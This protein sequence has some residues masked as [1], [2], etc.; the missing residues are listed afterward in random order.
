M[1]VSGLNS[2]L[3]SLMFWVLL[4]VVAVLIWNVSSRLQQNEHQMRFSDFIAAAESGKVQSVEIT[5]QQIKGVSIDNETF[6]S[7]AP[8]QYEGLANRL[9]ER[10]VV[11]QAK[12]PTA[13]PWASL[14][15]TW[16]PVLLMIGF[17]V[18]FMRQMQSGGNKALSFGKSKAKL[19]SNSQKKVTFKD[20]AGVDEAKEELQEIIEFLKEPQKFQKLGGRIPKGV[21]LMGSPGTGKTLLARAV[22]GEA[23]VPFF[24]I[25]GSDFVEMFVGVGAS[26][27]RD[28][29]EQGKKNAPCI[30]FID[31]IDAVGGR[32]GGSHVGA[33]DEREQTLNQLLAEMDGF[34]PAVGVVVLAA[35]NRPDVLDPALLRPG[36]F[37][38]RVVVSRP[39]VRGR[40]GILQV[41]TRK[42]P[43]S[44]DVDITTLARATP[45]VA[46]TLL[47]ASPGMREDSLNGPPRPSSTTHRSAAVFSIIASAAGV[48]IVGDIVYL[49]EVAELRRSETDA[50]AGV[51]RIGAGASLEQAWRA[52]A[53]P[54]PTPSTLIKLSLLMRYTRKVSP[55]FDVLFGVY[56][57]TDYGRRGIQYVHYPTYLRPRPMVDLRW[58]HQPRAGLELYYGLADRIARFGADEVVIVTT[59]DGATS[60]GEFW[61]SLNAAC[62]LG[63]PVVYVVE[64]N[65][66]AISVPVEVQTA[67]G[68]ISNLVSGFPGLNVVG[69]DGTDLVDSYRAAGEAIAY[70]RRRRRPSLIHATCTR[71][72]SH[73]MSDDETAYRTEEERAAQTERDPLT[74]AYALLV[75]FRI[76]T[77]LELDALA[78][79]VEAEVAAA[80]DEA[81][82]SPPPPPSSAMRHLYSEEVDPTSAAFD[83]E[84]APHVGSDKLL[85]MVDLINSCLK[86]EM[87]RD[88]RVVVLGQDVADCSR[89]PA[90]SEVKG[91]GGVFKVTYGLQREFGS[92]RVY[93]APIAEAGIVGRA[94]GMALRGLKPVVE[95]QFFDY[96][97]PAMMQIRGELATQRYRSN[98]VFAAPVVI[99]VAYGGYLKGGAIYHS[100]TGESIFAHCPGI[101]VCMPS[102]A[103]DAAGLLR[104]AIRCEDPV[105]FL[106]HKH[107][108]RQVYNKGRD[109]GP[110]F[111]IPFGKAAVR[112]SGA[113]VTVVTCG[114]LV[115]RS[116]DA[117]RIA[118]E[119][120]GI[121]AE[122][123]DLRTVKPLD[124]ECIAD[125]VKK[126]GKVLIVHED[127]LSWGIGAE[128]AAR[129]ADDLFEWLDGPVR[130][131]ASLDTW[132]AYAPGVEDATLPQTPDVV[133]AI[134]ELGEY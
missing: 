79:E 128:I 36:R 113:D 122:V 57:E 120:H 121:D 60:E 81:L 16:A 78:A 2:T 75:E 84:E 104:T 127:S 65:G 100:Q 9:I 107:L 126:T 119:E 105:L 101:H 1:G 66:Y 114:A 35:T 125:S 61:E 52:L 92:D 15:Y 76:A 33:N 129:V 12:E 68:S 102:T 31:E 83:T 95:I 45:G 87:A 70:T 37:D 133:E 22:A 74:K 134:V 117:A 96:I 46:A 17:W 49:G 8:D 44:E 64:D 47:C 67:G 54:L 55:G 50:G 42:I 116:L 27:V 112:R 26:R 41:H 73:S 18:F 25:S 108:Y 38:R 3:K 111:M 90:L 58:Y 4:V 118:H 91:K 32:R 131:V 10:G 59:G 13:S 63:L 80:S 53:D 106:E 85:T 124:M 39:D 97:W 98:G 29:F 132:V 71:P 19:S 51:L 20:V 6:H 7:Y 21:L 11:V 72:Y 109:P 48:P 14:F 86:S 43:L 99:R 77:P 110:D 69:C 103:V 89:E 82:A 93:N 23:N 30:V 24:S 62:A 94:I 56:N 28:L 40:E 88:P 130:R 115:K 5:G 123:I 34:D